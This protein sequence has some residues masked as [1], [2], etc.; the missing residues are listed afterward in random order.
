MTKVNQEIDKE[1][2][3]ALNL[4]DALDASTEQSTCL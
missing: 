2:M 4:L 3:S 1:A